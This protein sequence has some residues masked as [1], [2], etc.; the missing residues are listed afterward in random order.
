MVRVFATLENRF[1]ILNQKPFHP[2]CTQV[3]L[4]LACCILYNRILGWGIDAYFPNEVD[5]TPDGQDVGHGVEA[6]YQEA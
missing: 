1:K 4:V 3:K 6:N 2:F 5:V